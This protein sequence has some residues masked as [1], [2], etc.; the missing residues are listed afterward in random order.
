M[1][2]ICI[3]VILLL[4][5]IGSMPAFSEERAT[6]AVDPQ[7]GDVEFDA[8][9]GNL[10]IEARANLSEFI[11]NLSLTYGVKEETIEHLV[12]EEKM[13]P[14]DVYMTVGLADIVVEGSDE[15]NVEETLE[16]VIEEYKASQGKGWGY[17][18]KQLGIKPGSKEF[19]ELKKG[20]ILTLENTE[21]ETEDESET[22]SGKGKKKDKKP[23]KEK[24]KKK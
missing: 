20:G 6:V 24:S 1:R 13:E 14:A 10:N 8:V 23:K 12:V 2:R 18:A 11:T 5:C 22:T 7:T 21:S 16:I 19:H 15:A 3:T 4:T 9:L 17:I